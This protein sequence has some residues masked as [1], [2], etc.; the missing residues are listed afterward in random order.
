MHTIT[1]LWVKF[2]STLS[3]CYFYGE[4]WEVLHHFN[5]GLPPAGG[6]ACLLKSM[7]VSFMPCRLAVR[8]FLVHHQ[9]CC[10]MVVL[11]LV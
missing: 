10:S 2:F 3:N 8:D 1:Y 6:S 4:G 7:F 5:D 11:R 9:N